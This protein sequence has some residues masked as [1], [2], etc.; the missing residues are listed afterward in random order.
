MRR[1]R[2]EAEKCLE[3]IRVSAYGRSLC[4]QEREERI[5]IYDGDILWIRLDT[6]FLN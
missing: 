4:E 6:L 1:R 5:E 2:Q 3:A